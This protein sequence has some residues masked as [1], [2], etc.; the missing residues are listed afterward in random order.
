MRATRDRQR[1]QSQLNEPPSLRRI[2]KFMC[3]ILR[4][5]GVPDVIKFLRLFIVVSLA[6]HPQLRPIIRDFLD[7]SQDT[8]RLEPIYGTLG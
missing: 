3:N 7:D 1:M 8:R 4:P 5:P 2:S 6:N